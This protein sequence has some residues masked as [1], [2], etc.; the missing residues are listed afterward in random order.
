MIPVYRPLVGVSIF[1]ALSF[2]GTQELSC[3]PCP[4]WRYT[5]EVIGQQS[6]LTVTVGTWLGNVGICGLWGRWGFMGISRRGRGDRGVGCSLSEG[7]SRRTGILVC[8]LLQVVGAWCGDGLG[9][10]SSPHLRRRPLSL[11]FPFLVFPQA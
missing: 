9:L 8:A 11:F 7:F 6:W 5:V 4:L 1:T 10:W 2:S 3:V